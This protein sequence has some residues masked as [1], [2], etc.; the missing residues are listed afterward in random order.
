MTFS[1]L[2]RLWILASVLVLTPSL[3]AKKLITNQSVS[4]RAM[5][6]GESL[7]AGGGVA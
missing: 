3:Y 7:Y 2:S 1:N 4:I 6:T 5:S